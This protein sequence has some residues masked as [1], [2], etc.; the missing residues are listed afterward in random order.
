MVIVFS[1][2]LTVLLQFLSA[3]PPSLR[4]FWAARM[5]QLLSRSGALI[6][7][8]FP[9]H[10]LASS[11]GPPWSLPS[12]VYLELLKWPGKEISYDASGL[13]IETDEAK[14]SGKGLVRAAHYVPERTH[15]MGTVDGVVR[16]CISVWRHESYMMSGN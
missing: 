8:E 9:T 14:M 10:K 1:S 15:G 11:G 6:C 13:V 3:L 16:D 12:T 5:T 7:L 2:S 4:S